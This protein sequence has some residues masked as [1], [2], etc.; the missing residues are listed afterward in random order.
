MRDDT[1]EHFGIGKVV[2]RIWIAENGKTS[3]A[4]DT[5]ENEYSGVIA[6]AR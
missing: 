1:R 2:A 4:K 3:Q 5:V 6:N